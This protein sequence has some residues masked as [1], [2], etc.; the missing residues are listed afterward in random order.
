MLMQLRKACLAGDAVEALR[1]V[2]AAVPDYVP[3][4]QAKAAALRQQVGLRGKP[5]A[6]RAA[7]VARLV[8]SR[9]LA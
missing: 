5:R 1:A 9:Q 3:S 7:D 4:Q 6:R 2:C 8:H